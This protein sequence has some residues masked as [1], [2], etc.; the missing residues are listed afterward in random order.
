MTIVGETVSGSGH[1]NYRDNELNIDNVPNVL[2][3]IVDQIPDVLMLVDRKFDAVWTNRAAR[4]LLRHA[5]Y[6]HSPGRSHLPLYRFWFEGEGAF[7]FAAV[8]KTFLTGVQQEEVFDDMRGLT[9][10]MKVF[11]P[12]AVGCGVDVVIIFASDVTEK[13]QLRGEALRT[14]QMAMLGQLAAGVAHEINNPINGI[15]NYAQ[16]IADRSSPDSEEQQLSKDIIVE[17]TRIAGITSKLLA[18]ARDQ[19]SQKTPA[20]P[21]DLI[22]S[23]LMLSE[24]QMRNEGIAL[25]V[26][27]PDD[28]P[29]LLVQREQIQQLLLNLLNNARYALNQKYPCGSSGKTLVI[30]ARRV[31]I[32][33][34]LFVQFEFLDNGTGIKKENLDKIFDPFYTAKLNREGIGLG[35]SVSKGIV[36]RHGGR[37]TIRTEAD[38]YTQVV[39]EFPAHPGVEEVYEKQD[40]GC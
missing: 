39:F 38:S 20:A 11:P 40:S 35:L 36:K 12:I 23:A 7:D 19:H 4:K 32:N 22:Q 30:N 27:I 31:L 6:E 13:L 1:R 37:I 8:R 9:W 33:D 25:K 5:A 24:N 26:D 2:Q 17:G 16:L 14:G 18:F 15:I 21:C 3:E 28:L 10:G 29:M 34:R